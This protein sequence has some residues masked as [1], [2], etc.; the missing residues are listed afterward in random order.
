M[1]SVTQ[2]SYYV[3]GKNEEPVFLNQA[4]NVGIDILFWYI[5][6]WYT[7]YFPSTDFI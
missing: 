5:L 4:V 6:F 7:P 2:Q 1:R 3:M